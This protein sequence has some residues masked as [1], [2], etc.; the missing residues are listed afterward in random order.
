MIGINMEVSDMANNSMGERIREMLEK[1][2]MTQR[3]L[4]IKADITEAAVSHYIKG[5]RVPRATVLARIA[6]AM[7][8]TPEYLLEG[9]PTNVKEELGYAK[10]LIARNV[11]QMTRGEKLEFIEILMGKDDD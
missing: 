7:N 4:A 1:N 8:T 5:D 3:E 11:K 10:K 9:I 2:E 6:H